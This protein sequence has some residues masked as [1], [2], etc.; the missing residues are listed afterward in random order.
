MRETRLVLDELDSILSEELFRE[1]GPLYRFPADNQVLQKREGYREI[2]RAY[3]QF[4]VASKLA[5]SGGEDVYGAGQRDVATLYEY[6]VFLKLA[7]V[8]SDLCDVKFNFSSLIEVQKDGL[9]VS[10]RKGKAKVLTGTVVRLG[11]ELALELWF[12]RTYSSSK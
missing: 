10:L 3:I 1:V 7:Q 8:I 2:L 9:N 5:W 12:N 6:W 4:E 11:R